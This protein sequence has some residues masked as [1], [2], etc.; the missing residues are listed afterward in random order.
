MLYRTKD[1]IER[2]VFKRLKYILNELSIQQESGTVRFSWE[3]SAHWLG[4][5]GAFL[6][7]IRYPTFLRRISTQIITL[8]VNGWSLHFK[9]SEVSK[10]LESFPFLLYPDVSS[11]VPNHT[12]VKMPNRSAKCLN[13]DT[14]MPH[15]HIANSLEKLALILPVG[16][17]VRG[18][19][20][21]NHN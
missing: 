18:S 10:T 2:S 8:T 20:L 17:S 13:L 21:Y 19:A 9:V 16:F 6:G 5:L 15:H 7:T 11:Q 3:C 12:N 14:K 4:R 1:Q